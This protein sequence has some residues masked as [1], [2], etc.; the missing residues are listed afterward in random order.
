MMTPKTIT[1][2]F[3]RT[4]IFGFSSRIVQV[5]ISTETGVVAY[6]SNTHERETLSIWIKATD[7]KR[8]AW[9]EQMR[10]SEKNNPIGMIVKIYVLA[11]IL[12]SR[13]P[14]KSRARARICVQIVA[15]IKCHVVKKIGKPD[16][17][18]KKGARYIRNPAVSR[19][20]LL[21]KMT[22]PLKNIQI[23]DNG[24]PGR[25]VFL[26]RQRTLD[27]VGN[28]ALPILSDHQGTHSLT[29][30]PLRLFSSLYRDVSMRNLWCDRVKVLRS[31]LRQ[32]SRKEA[33]V[34]A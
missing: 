9:L 34:G 25:E 11:S 7:R 12:T 24:Y 13:M 33:S 28:S 23:L 8:Y 1:V 15:K 17:V 16:R 10:D 22:E 3:P 31:P 20:H 26:T 5:A 19:T 18:R 2:T 14:L 27:G 30:L 29:R 4:F 21:N 6:L 32:F